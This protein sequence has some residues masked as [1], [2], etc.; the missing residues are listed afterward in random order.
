[1]DIL[2]LQYFQ[3]IARLENVSR[4]SELLYVAQ[5]NLSTSIK[6]LEEDLGVA[7][8]ERRKGRIRLT[9]TG[10][11]FLASVDD[12]LGELDEA[13]A[14]AREMDSRAGERL[15]I[16]SVIVDLIGMLLSD[17]LREHPDVSVRQFNCRN[18]E[19]VGKI[20]NADADFGFVFG[21][22]SVQ[23]LE[24]LE[25]D[26]CERIVQLSKDH[27]L[28]SREIIDL[29]DLTGERL[30]INLS[31]DDEELVRDL[32]KSRRFRPEIF[33][34]CD[35]QRV[36]IGMITQSRG[37]SIAPLSNY[38]KLIHSDPSLNMTCLRIREE[39]PPSCLG[40]LRKSG[41]RLSRAALQFYEIVNGFF[42][43]EQEIALQFAGKLPSRS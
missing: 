5:P 17:F 12:I 21:T 23:G 6:R 30:I 2:Q 34:E 38:L 40:M 42:S 39:L 28:A 31:R 33:Y 22:P 43:R 11:V 19:V 26:R 35:D 20:L 9:E 14:R 3:T 36:E 37:L 7:L 13:V 15:R 29:D 32:S 8:F 16:A 27:A 24:Y 41:V 25:V 4:A 1:M 10:R 18:S